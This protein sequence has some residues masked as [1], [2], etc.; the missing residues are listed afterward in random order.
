MQQSCYLGMVEQPSPAGGYANSLYGGTDSATRQFLSL[1]RLKPDTLLMPGRNLI[2]PM[3]G[4][5][6]GQH[7]TWVSEQVGELRPIPAS[8]L[9]AQRFNQNYDLLDFMS[10]HD[11]AMEGAGTMIGGVADHLETRTRLIRKDFSELLGVYRDAQRQGVAFNSLDFA[12]MRKP[13]EA[14]L[15]SQ[16]TGMARKAL[17]EAPNATK[18]KKGLG[19][20]HKSIAKEFK[21]D[22]N[23]DPKWYAR[24]IGRTEGLAKNIKR[25]GTVGK[26][27]SIGSSVTTVANDYRSGGWQGGLRSAGQEASGIGGS[28]LGGMAGGAVATST[29]VLLFGAAT[30]GAG[31]VLIGIGVVVGS[32]AGGEI[33]EAGYNGGYQLLFK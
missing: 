32:I 20:S 1:N 16:I 26:V 22:P 14:R 6:A 24:A 31:F 29:A 5:S 11:G 33:A 23:V 12:A 3:P 18:V 8:A 4:E 19:I 21:L 28:A 15:K 2:M 27:L 17:Y 10:Q 7:M 25:L 30:G 9:Q 13:V